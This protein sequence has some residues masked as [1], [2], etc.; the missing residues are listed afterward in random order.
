MEWFPAM[1]GRSPVSHQIP[2][3]DVKTFTM[4]RCFDKFT[5]KGCMVRKYLDLPVLNVPSHYF[6]CGQNEAASLAHTKTSLVP[7]IPQLVESQECYE[8]ILAHDQLKAQLD[9]FC[10]T[11]Q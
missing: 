6:E 10:T 8:N 4:R 2:R 11:T 1:S 9:P 3:R 7:R 5:G